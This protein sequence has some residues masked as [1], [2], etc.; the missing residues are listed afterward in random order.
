MTEA[1][2]TELPRIFKAKFRKYF[3]WFS[4]YPDEG[5]MLF[6]AKSK[7]NAL[8]RARKELADGDPET[9]L[10]VQRATPAQAKAW[11]ALP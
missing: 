9:E 2:K 10:T 4:E 3:V 5:S 7:R 11:E 8:A 6:R 1:V